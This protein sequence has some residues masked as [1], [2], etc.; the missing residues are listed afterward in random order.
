R[1][2]AAPRVTKSVFVRVTRQF[3]G[4]EVTPEFSFGGQELTS[5]VLH[6]L[7]A[8][9]ARAQSMAVRR[10]RRTVIDTDVILS[11]PEI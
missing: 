4:E 2:P 3:L 11:F 7:R 10:R 5:A 1:D 9:F 8:L 6:Q